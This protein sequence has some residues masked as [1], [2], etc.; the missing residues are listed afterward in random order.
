[1]FLVVYMAITQSMMLLQKTYIQPSQALQS[2]IYFFD[3]SLFNC[4]RFFNENVVKKGTTGLRNQSN[5]LI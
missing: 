5:K 2:P 1:M 4:G 3:T